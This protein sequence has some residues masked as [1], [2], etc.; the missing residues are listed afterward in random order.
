VRYAARTDD[1]KAAI[2]AA[3][4]AGG[5]KVYDLQRPVDLLV[6]IGDHLLLVEIKDGDKSPSRQGYTR[7]QQAFLGDGWPVT[8]VRSIEGVRALLAAWA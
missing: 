5:A 7:A 1:N 6:L 3:L 2:V 4:R 8:T